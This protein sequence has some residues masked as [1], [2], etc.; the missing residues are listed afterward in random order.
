[1]EEAVEPEPDR[2]DVGA[3]LPRSART[4]RTAL[5]GAS[6]RSSPARP[7]AVQRVAPAIRRWGQL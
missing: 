3:R 2:A 5:Q 4:E 6:P 7:R 1:M